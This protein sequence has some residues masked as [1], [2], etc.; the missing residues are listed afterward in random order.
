MP[1]PT[2]NPRSSIHGISIQAGSIDSTAIGAQ[3]VVA[4]DISDGSIISPKLG[5][6]AIGPTAL[7]SSAVTTAKLASTSVISPKIGTSAI[8]ATHLAS[9]AVI[10]PKLGTGAVGPTGLASSA[11][12]TV[13][14]ASAAVVGP[15]IGTA[16]VGLTAAATVLKRNLH[17]VSLGQQATGGIKNRL[18]F[19]SPPSGSTILAAKFNAGTAMY[20]AAGEADT[21]IFQLRNQSAAV[22]LI[23]NN[24]SLSGV[25]LGLTAFKTLPV[26]SGNSTL[27][28]NA[29]LF[30]QLSVSGTAQTLVNASFH[31]E[32][33]PLNNA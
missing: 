23:Q 18:V 24:A 8:G 30:A 26:N 11:V 6:A 33:S 20:H 31:I 7:A 15:K 10:S 27:L 21:W 13:K 3:V 2:F 16:A 25:T 29:G 1:R 12:T 32:W 28:A 14:I 22:N 5:T 19:V 4:A 17:T 9:A